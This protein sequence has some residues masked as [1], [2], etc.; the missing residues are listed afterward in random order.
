MLHLMSH[1]FEVQG[2]DADALDNFVSR[3]SLVGGT[4]VNSSCCQLVPKKVL[5]VEAL[6]D[7]LA[8]VM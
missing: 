5:I 8:P 3:T 6:I 2:V 4:L 7:R 1:E